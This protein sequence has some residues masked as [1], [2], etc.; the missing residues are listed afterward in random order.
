[1]GDSVIAAQL[2]TLR[3]F[4]KTVEDIRSTFARVRELG[5]EAVQVSGMGAIEPGQLKRIAEESE[6]KIIATH[7]SYQR[8]V[9]DVE[10][11]HRRT[12]DVGMSSRG[13]R[14]TARRV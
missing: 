14:W 5:Y 4:T 6:L 13:D 12:Q 10:A 9:E 2:Y 7:I 8:I 1:M 3:D 11:S